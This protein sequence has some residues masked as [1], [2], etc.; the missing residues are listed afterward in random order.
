MALTTFQKSILRVIAGNRSQNSHFAGAG[1]NRSAGRFSEDLDLFYD[2]RMILRESVTRDLAS[3]RDAGF[4][5]YLKSQLVEETG[6]AEAKVQRGMEETTIEWSCDSIHRFFPARQDD[7]FGWRLHPFDRA[8]NKVLA[9]AG[10]REAR[11]YV[12]VIE[13][14]RSHYSIATLA[15]AAPAKDPGFTPQLVLD[16]MTRHAKFTLEEYRWVETTETIDPVALKKEFLDAVFSAREILSTLPL[17]SAG[18]VFI[19]ATAKIRALTADVAG[20]PGISW[21]TASSYGALPRFFCAGT[22]I[23]EITPEPVSRAVP[24]GGRTIAYGSGRSG[25][26]E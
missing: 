16:E 11:D 21:H 23:D 26:N 18:C 9:L 8:T 2:S 10:R 7:Q 12:D 24:Q 1:L 25:C 4:D 3:L 20:E 17:E 19:D 22:A 6:R 13:L 14:N 15:W 5:V